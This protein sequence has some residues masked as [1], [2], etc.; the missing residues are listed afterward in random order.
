MIERKLLQ[1]RHDAARLRA[2][3]VLTEDR[4]GADETLWNAVL[5]NLL[6]TVQPCIGLALHT[7]VHDAL[8]T[9]TAAGSAHVY[10]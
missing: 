10:Q 3:G 6:Q 5:M 2:Y 8:G 9:P 4:L 7:V 1:V